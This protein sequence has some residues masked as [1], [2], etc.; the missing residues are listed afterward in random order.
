LTVGGNMNNHQYW[1]WGNR[2]SQGAGQVIGSATGGSGSTALVIQFGA[3][4]GYTSAWIGGNTWQCPVDGVWMTMGSFMAFPHSNQGYFWIEVRR[5]KNDA[6]TLLSLGGQLD[7]HTPYRDSVY[8]SWQFKQAHYCKKGEKLQVW[9]L[10]SGTN[11]YMELHG[12]W[13]NINIFKIG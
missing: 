5:Y 4:A 6:Q 8:Q 12:F 3:N 2:N 9:Y 10:C 7:M 13:G 1:F 11:A